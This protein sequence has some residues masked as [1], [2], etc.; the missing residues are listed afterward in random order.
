[1]HD[2]LIK[3]LPKFRRD[4]IKVANF[5]DFKIYFDRQ[6][7]EN[8]D[9]QKKFRHW[10]EK[11]RRDKVDLI[12]ISAA[13]I[14]VNSFVKKLNPKSDL[15]IAIIAPGNDVTTAM[16]T[17]FVYTENFVKAEVKQLLENDGVIGLVLHDNI[18]VPTSIYM[19]A[20]YGIPIL[21]SDVEPV[22]SIICDYQIGRSFNV[23]SNV[24]D[25]INELKQNYNF[26]SKNTQRFLQENSWY[27]SML[28]HQEIWA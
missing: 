19:F 12:Y 18:S 24:H 15:A 25:E 13:R 10:Q 26:Y 17:I 2:D 21:G 28:V 1:M 11:I 5:G 7:N 16:D 8:K 9:F 4:K 22:R 20:S 14:D 6:Q 23:R 3:Y 27:K